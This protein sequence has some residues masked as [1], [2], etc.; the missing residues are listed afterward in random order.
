MKKNISKRT[1]ITQV[2]GSV[3]IGPQKKIVVVSQ[4]GPTWSL[5]KG[6][7]EAGESAREA[8]VREA[9]E[10]AGLTELKLIEEL[11]AYERYRT[12][13]TGG[14]DTSELKQIEM[15]MFSTEEVDLKPIDPTIPGA[16]WVDID[17]VPGL[18]THPKDKEFFL[19]VIPK[20]N[21]FIISM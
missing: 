18:L 7:I 4:H 17:E 1:R 21:T 6:H 10:E 11:G 3:I 12:G 13:K 16:E 8:A 15:F 2:A 14:V 20:I 5:P 9:E 19:S